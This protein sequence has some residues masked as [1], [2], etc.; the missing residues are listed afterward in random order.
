MDERHQHTLGEPHIKL[1]G[2]QIWVQRR[3]FPDSNDYW[4]GNWLQVVTHCGASG[5]NVWV[6]G[7]ILHLSEIKSWQ[8]SIEKLYK[9]LSGEANLN[10]MEPE[11]YVSL[12]SK[13]LGQIEM[14]VQITP[15]HLSQEHRYT[16]M[17]DQSYLK[18]LLASCKRILKEYPIKGKP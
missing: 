1:S 10:C 5:S 16:F 18:P 11:L 7:P 12:K 3:Q 9:T 15:E 8:D 17:L 2:L 14:E 4:D 6:S 13:K